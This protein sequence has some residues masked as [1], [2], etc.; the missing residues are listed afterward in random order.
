M[1]STEK[2]LLLIVFLLM[3]T[4]IAGASHTNN[5]ALFENLQGINATNITLTGVG[6]TFPDGT[7]QTTSSNASSSGW[8][9]DGTV[10]R[11]TTSTDFV[12]IG[13]TDPDVPLDIEGGANVQLKLGTIN[14]FFEFGRFV[15]TGALHIQGSQV[16]FNNIVLAPTSGNVGIG[17]ASPSATLDIAGSL[18]ATENITADNIFK[19]TII[20]AHTDETFLLVQNN[21]S[22]MTFGHEVAVVQSNVNHTFNDFSNIT[23]YIKEDGLY[24]IKYNVNLIDSAAS[25]SAEVAMR[26]LVNGAEL[27][28]S[29]EEGVTS[30]QNDEL[31]LHD[32]AYVRLAK[33]DQIKLQ[34]I[35][36]DTTVSVET[37]GTFG[38]DKDSASI[39]I[40]KIAS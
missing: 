18:N 32:F 27:E 13:I 40:H 4:I 14:L 8:T 15:A 25:P 35:S 21:W 38:D 33:E 2:V 29:V 31:S 39:S 34:V 26:I 7:V 17:E 20:W 11:L 19:T 36:D 24:H 9:D 37:H 5:F 28:G 16:G 3:S 23:F 22:N 1:K 12:G 10:V 6:V 30:K